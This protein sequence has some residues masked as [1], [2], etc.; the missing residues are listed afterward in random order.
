MK[1]IIRLYESEL[2]S[3]VKRT[4]MESYN[5]KIEL[6]S[7]TYNQRKKIES[8]GAKVLENI[9]NFTKQTEEGKKDI[10]YWLNK[11]GLSLTK[12]SN[13]YIAK[14]IE[15][16]EFAIENL[17]LGWKENV[18]KEKLNLFKLQQ[19]NP[20]EN[21]IVLFY[22][23]VGDDLKWSYVNLY[24]TNVI[25]WIRLMN[26]RYDSSTKENIDSLIREYFGDLSVNTFAAKDMFKS[27]M[28]ERQVLSKQIFDKTWGGGR[29]VEIAF[30]K[31]L[32]ELGIKGDDIKVFGGEGNWVD[33]FG[34]D[35]AFK[36]K[37]T[38]IPVQVKSK[39]ESAK[40]SIPF[41]GVSAY[42]EN[43]EFFVY[44]GENDPIELKKFLSE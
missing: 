18:L 42:P 31:K 10:N 9:K 7:L 17:P 23:I 3:L 6:S 29:E 5:N 43:S 13:E 37:G 12:P 1:K 41:Q 11:H 27:M 44:D 39:K 2:V 14:N 24:D 8:S 16:I 19:E 15:D 33:R 30:V 34:I 25:F 40:K 35:L 22:E 20:T 26:K 4:I 32:L 38:Y 36:F 21:F 28:N